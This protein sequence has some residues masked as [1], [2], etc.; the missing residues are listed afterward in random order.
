MIPKLSGLNCPKCGAALEI[1]SFGN[2]LNIVC[3]SCLSILDAKDPNL[4][5][6]QE[7][8][9][10]EKVPLIIPLGQRGTVNG[11]KYEVIGFQV[12]SVA[13]EEAPWQWQ[14]Y[15]L[16]NPYHGFRYLTEYNGHWN[17]VRVIQAL[18]EPV[19]GR[20]VRYNGETYTHFSDAN[21]TTSYVIGEFPWQIRVG[22]TIATSDFINPPHLLLSETTADE[23]V[24]SL[25][26]YITPADLWKAFALPGVPGPTFGVFENQPSPYANRS[27]LWML[28]I[29][30]VA[31]AGILSVLLSAIASHAEVLSQTVVVGAQET[32]AI[33]R[34]FE[35]GGHTS[36]LE[37]HTQNK[38][39][40]SLYIDYS[41]VNE[42]S[43]QAT[44]FH[45]EVEHDNRVLLP[46]IPPGRYSLRAQPDRR[47]AEFT[48]TVRRDVPSFTF[49]WIAAVLLLIPPIMQSWQKLSFERQRWQS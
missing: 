35:V 47:P 24:W 26:E 1:R 8:Q 49:F 21:A 41:L 37:I 45:R 25:G 46:T 14:E 39:S 4:R 27:G 29:G 18:P 33:T 16:F 44:Q 5:I 6:L 7:A 15:L 40:Q 17:F 10:K 36:N 32:T 13:D 19:S 23:T 38:M 30:T 22:D 20:T 28:A 2:A 12:R 34:P 48:V 11:V 43:G 42:S 3:P 9:A 31:A